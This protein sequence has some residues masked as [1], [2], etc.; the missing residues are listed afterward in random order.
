MAKVIKQKDILK[1]FKIKKV[2]S[3]KFWNMK[4][5]LKSIDNYKVL[6]NYS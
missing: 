6:Q 1:D 5:S 2:L 3:K 4:K